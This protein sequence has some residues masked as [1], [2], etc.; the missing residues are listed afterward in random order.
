MRSQPFI[1]GRGFSSVEYAL[2]NGLVD[3]V[4]GCPNL[5]RLIATTIA[6]RETLIRSYNVNG[7]PAVIQN[8]VL[9]TGQQ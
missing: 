9:R 1:A 4:N 5:N 7:V 2:K 8:G 3:K 6:E